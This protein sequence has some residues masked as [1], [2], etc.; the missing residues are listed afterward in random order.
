MSI[1]AVRWAYS[2]PL[3]SPA[4]RLTLV[5]MADYVD[6]K[7]MYFVPIEKLQKK[8][9]LSKRTLGATIRE[10][11]KKGYLVDTGERKGRTKSV[12]VYHLVIH[13]ASEVNKRDAD[14][15]DDRHKDAGSEATIA[16]LEGGSEATI[17]SLQTRKR[18]E[19]PSHSSV[20]STVGKS[21]QNKRSNSNSM[22]PQRARRRKKRF[23]FTPP[24]REEMVA[25]CVENGYDPN[26]G[27]RAFLYY[28]TANPPWTDRT[29]NPVR[30]WKQ[31][32]ISLWFKPENKIKHAK[33][34]TITCEVCGTRRPE[35][36]PRC[37]KCSPPARPEKVR[38]HLANLKSL[39]GSLHEQV[40]Y[41]SASNPNEKF[42]CEK[43]QHVHS[44]NAACP[45]ERRLQPSTTVP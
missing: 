17:A 8:T 27:N 6:E 4:Q 36:E 18:A 12:V 41:P 29:G 24:T 31:K 30:S 22:S 14:V 16:S 35:Y 21:E 37:I 44:P 10:L 13:P 23:V 42:R 28:S 5:S 40:T 1:R 2:L 43:C 9:L 19:K 32:L 39:F 3:T 11:K 38:E 26:V 34:R 33:P 20:S 15:A 45:Q 25:Y 7:E